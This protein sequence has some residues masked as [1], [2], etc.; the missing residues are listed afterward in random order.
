M[1][2]EHDFVLV[3]NPVQNGETVYLEFSESLS[4][5]PIT[6]QM[7]NGSGRVEQQLDKVVDSTL[8]MQL[9]S[10]KKSGLYI[11][12]VISSKGRISKKLI[13]Q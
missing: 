13:V 8:E 12:Q 9:S 10:P 6:V 11:I 7:I 3:K 2:G 5:Q 4:A 1:Q